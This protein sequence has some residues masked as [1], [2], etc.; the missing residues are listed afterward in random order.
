MRDYNL[1]D[2]ENLDIKEN[3]DELWKAIQASDSKKI[4]QIWKELEHQIAILQGTIAV[5]RS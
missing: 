2:K 3:L 1:G 4:N 5:F